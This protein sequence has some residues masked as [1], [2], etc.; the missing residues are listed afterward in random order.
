MPTYDYFN[1][2]VFFLIDW[3]ISLVNFQTFIFHRLRM[4]EWDEVEIAAKS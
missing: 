2:F 4:T 1:L 3:L